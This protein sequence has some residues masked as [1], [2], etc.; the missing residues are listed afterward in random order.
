MACL[1]S[2]RYRQSDTP[3][4]RTLRVSDT[5]STEA[6]V[7]GLKAGREY[8]FMVLSQDEHGDGMFSKAIRVKTAG[9]GHAP[10]PRRRGGKRVSVNHHSLPNFL[11][12]FFSN[13][14]PAPWRRSLT[15]I[16]HR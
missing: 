16:E 10:T 8:E 1:P 9:K 12:F 14:E 15:S 13:Q 4:W 3:E 5:D 7:S 11:T 2:P 6:L